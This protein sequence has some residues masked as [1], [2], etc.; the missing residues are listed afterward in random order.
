MAWSQRRL[1]EVDKKTKVIVNYNVYALLVEYK[2]ID[3]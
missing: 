3:N 2:I 1:I